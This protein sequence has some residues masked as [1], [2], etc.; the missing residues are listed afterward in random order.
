MSLEQFYGLEGQPFG[1]TPDPRYY[2]EVAQRTEILLR[3][4]YVAE[5][6]KGLAVVIGD[7]GTGKTTLARQLLDRLD[8]ERYESALLVVIHSVVTPEWL[9]SKIALQLGVDEAGSDRPAVIARLYE[10]LLGLHEAGRRAVVLIDEANL[11]S[12]REILAEIRGLLNLEVPGGKLLTFV[13]FG[14]PSL[15][16]DLGRD[17]PLAQRVALVCRLAPLPAEATEAYVRHRLK[18][19][20]GGRDLF[21]AAALEAIH[22]WSRG[23]PRVINTLCDNALLEGY[24]RR[25]E[26]LDATLIDDLACDLGIDADAHRP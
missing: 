7:V 12:S 16:A 2:F 24:L 20:G 23:I 15:E 25:R 11:L 14:L 1:H 13:L 8:G 4:Q 21:S 6:A 5:T 22:R 9:L 10:R 19:A 17:A 18:A 26:L 3:L